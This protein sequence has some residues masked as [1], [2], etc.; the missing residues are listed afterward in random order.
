M[1][2]DFDLSSLSW[3]EK[4]FT[5]IHELKLQACQER[6]SFWPDCCLF[7]D[8]TDERAEELW[9]I[10]F[11][12]EEHPCSAALHTADYLE[13]QVR[14]EL[15]EQQLF[16]PVSEQ[17]LL[18]R[19]YAEGGQTSLHD[20]YELFDAEALVRKLWCFLDWDEAGNYTLSLPPTLGM[21]LT[22]LGASF[23][24][25]FTRQKALSCHQR[26]TGLLSAF[27]AMLYEDAVGLFYR[28]LSE[29]TQP[30]AA[31]LL[32]RSILSAYDWVSDQRGSIVLLHPAC[33]E[34][35]LVLSQI[36]SIAPFF[37]ST[38][39]SDWMEASSEEEK[40]AAVSLATAVYPVARPEMTAHGVVENIRF[41][42][43]Q[44]AGL[45]DLVEILQSMIICRPTEALIGALQRIREHTPRWIFCTDSAEAQ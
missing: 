37:Q 20:P 6:M 43:K 13:R 21:Y 26:I 18:D 1:R 33:V 8:L 41:A 2:R 45:A 34:V 39:S 9:R 42:A 23:D 25:S 10:S 32:R 3:A 12:A 5:R 28:D 44:G 30:H 35:P 24:F 19:I 22:F 7:E 31:R 16:L 11:D 40:K 15:F 4:T 27:G 17:R 36:R 38:W 29:Y 14:E